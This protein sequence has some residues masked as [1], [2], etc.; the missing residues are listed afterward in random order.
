MT[1]QIL[2]QDFEA[3]DRPYSLKELAIM[4]EKAYRALR[5]GKTKAKHQS[6]GHFYFVKENSRKEK[7]ILD[8]NSDDVGNC[9]VCWKLNKVDRHLKFRAKNLVHTYSSSFYE[10]PKYL[11]YWSVTMETVFYKWLYEN[12]DHTNKK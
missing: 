5:L 3:P 6:C 4:R 7:E 12:K 9:S 1:T 2:E 10:E 11:T 8:Q